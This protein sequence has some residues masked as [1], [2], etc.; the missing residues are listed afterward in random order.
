[1]SWLPIT[2]RSNAMRRSSES[3]RKAAQM[4][5]CNLSTSKVP[6]TDMSIYEENEREEQKTEI[7]G[8]GCIE[9]NHSNS[10]TSDN[11]ST[12]WS[13]CHNIENVHCDMAPKKA[14][15]S[16]SNW[17]LP[18]ICVTWCRVFECPWACV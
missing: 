1:M 6:L 9:D 18:V 3:G 11:I 2:K 16:R 17:R 12:S 10:R 4:R 14:G 15:S 7:W 13:V 8:A 5:S